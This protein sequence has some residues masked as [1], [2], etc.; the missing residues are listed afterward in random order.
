MFA[1]NSLVRS[2]PKSNCSSPFPLLTTTFFNFNLSSSNRLTTT[3]VKNLCCCNSMEGRAGGNK[4][5]KEEK[6]SNN[7]SNL[8]NLN[9]VQQLINND[10]TGGWDK[11]WEQALTPWDLG[12]PTPVIL[13]LLKTGALPKGRVLIPG[14][15]SGHDVVAIAGPERYVVGLDISE[16]ALNK[17]REL[18]SS[19]QNASHYAFVKEDFFT[20]NPPSLFDLIFDYTFF[21]AIEPS[22]RPAWASRIHDLLK[23]DG[24]LITLMFPI[25]DYIGGPPYKVSVADYE[26]VLHSMEFKAISV[27][28]N[29]L[30]VGARKGREKLGRWKRSLAE[31]CL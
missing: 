6:I 22:K 3:R 5:E 17:A 8:P 7:N 24:E 4:V 18:F 20:W 1:R 23:P 16:N 21:C 27:I 19:S 28:D 29:E 2:V 14:C 10:S 11:C 12:G 25:D 9:Q 15:G 30:A 13:N 26:E 31:S